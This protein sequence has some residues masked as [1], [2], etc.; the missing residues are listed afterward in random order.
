MNGAFHSRPPLLIFCLSASTAAVILAT[1]TAANLPEVVM[2]SRPGIDIQVGHNRLMGLVRKNF[3]ISPFDSGICPVR[4][5]NRRDR[6]QSAIQYLPAERCPRRGP[7][8][9]K[10]F[11]FPIKRAIT[12]NR[13]LG[14]TTSCGVAFVFVLVCI[15]TAL[16]FTSVP[17]S[18][19]Q[20]A[21]ETVVQ[22]NSDCRV[23]ASTRG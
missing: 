5:R 15:R 20:F 11:P 3:G 10:I 2:Q 12:G 8:R 7:R 18:A 22:P 17:E 4:P 9:I 13:F 16:D 1:W 19:V 14:S 21:G 6:N 23:S